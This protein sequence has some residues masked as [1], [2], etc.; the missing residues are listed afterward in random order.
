MV[1]FGEGGDFV[2]L[3]DDRLEAVMPEPRWQ[4][5]QV[6]GGD[7]AGIGGLFLMEQD[8]RLEVIVV[9]AGG[10]FGRINF[11]KTL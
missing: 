5:R 3:V 7:G 10:Q 6:A 11:V 9:E 8:H 2:G 4:G 1:G